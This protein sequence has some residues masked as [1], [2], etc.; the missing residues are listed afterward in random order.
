[1][2]PGNALS[3][4]FMQVSSVVSCTSKGGGGEIA[5]GDEDSE[6]VADENKETEHDKRLS[7]GGI[8]GPDPS[9]HVV[10][11]NSAVGGG[12]FKFVFSISP[13]SLYWPLSLCAPPMPEAE[14]P[15]DDG[16]TGEEDG[17]LSANTNSGWG[18]S[19]TP[20]CAGA[21]TPQVVFTFAFP[22]AARRGS[23]NSGV[24]TSDMH[25]SLSA[26]ALSFPL[27]LALL[28]LPMNLCDTSGIISVSTSAQAVLTTT[29]TC[30]L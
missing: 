13:C 3:Q 10:D 5:G 28:R 18:M 11:A 26:L 25:A 19:S 24:E 12:F 7:R 2:I 23:G 15:S 1:M 4:T 20:L 22:L 30:M 8:V 9:V 6:M 16:D 29:G 14:R 17:F 21:W 27:G